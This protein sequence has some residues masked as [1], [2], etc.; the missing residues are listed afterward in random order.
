MCPL[1]C[2]NIIYFQANQVVLVHLVLEDFQVP[3]GHQVPQE[4]M[5]Y[6]AYQGQQVHRARLDLPDYVETLVLQ[7]IQETLVA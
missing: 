5:D 7:E 6:Q 3:R 4:V 2:T 1:F